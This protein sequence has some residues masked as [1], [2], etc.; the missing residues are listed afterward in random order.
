VTFGLGA[1]VAI[2]VALV[3][4]L[5]VALAVMLAGCSASG[6]RSCLW[7]HPPYACPQH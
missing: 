5:T 2:T 6:S 3:I 1:V 7:L 4:V